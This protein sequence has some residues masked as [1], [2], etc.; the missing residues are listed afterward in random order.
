MTVTFIG[1]GVYSV[2]GPNPRAPSTLVTDFQN[3]WGCNA[4]GHGYY[5]VDRSE[6]K[7]LCEHVQAVL[8]R[9]AQNGRSA[10]MT[11]NHGCAVL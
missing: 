1:N 9:E 10:A 2:R 11:K 6:A 3:L 8:E 7:P 5:D 4:P